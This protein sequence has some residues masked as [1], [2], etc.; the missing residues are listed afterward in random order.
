[1]QGKVWISP[2]TL[3]FDELIN[4]C[5]SL[6]T[7]EGCIYVYT[8]IIQRCCEFDVCVEEYLGN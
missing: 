2:Y 7:F 6:G 3:I 5:A 8:Q 1:M 4:A